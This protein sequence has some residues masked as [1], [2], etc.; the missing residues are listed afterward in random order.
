M[1]D[2]KDVV[3]TVAPALA[4]AL[5]TP[6]AGTAVKVLSDVFLGVPDAPA[7]AVE[8]AVLNATPNQLLAL[9]TADQEYALKLK[10]LEID[11]EKTYIKDTNDARLA[12]ASDQRVF[13]LGVAI[14]LTFAGAVTG[15]LYSAHQILLTGMQ[16][17]DP[18]TAAVVF[19]LIGTLVGYV[20][21]NAQQVIGFF[22]GSSMGSKDKTAALADAIQKVGQ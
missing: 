8:S 22:F 15:V 21:A 18:G 12:H 4:T 5:G 19:T 6:L 13:W 17:A 7:S 1:P 16:I 3:R 14:L 9:K 10:E 11:L 20:A 2:W